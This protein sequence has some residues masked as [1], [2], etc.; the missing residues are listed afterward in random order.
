MPNWHCRLQVVDTSKS[1]LQS[2]LKFHKWIPSLKLTA[3]AHENPHRNPGKCHQNGGCSMAML[4]YRR[5]QMEFKR[6]QETSVFET[7]SPTVEAK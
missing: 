4:V 1:Q 5:V 7:L 6:L 3:K 2:Q